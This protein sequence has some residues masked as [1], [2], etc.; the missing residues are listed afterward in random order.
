MKM[1]SFIIVNCSSESDNDELNIKFYAK[2]VSL[3]IGNTTALC[4]TEL[5][6]NKN[7]FRWKITFFESP[8]CFFVFI[9]IHL[10]VF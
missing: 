8:I 10:M 5:R 1:Q 2:V 6:I 4:Y 3:N 9:C 7:A